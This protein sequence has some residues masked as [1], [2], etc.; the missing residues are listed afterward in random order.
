MFVYFILASFIRIEDTPINHF[1]LDN[2]PL[3]PTLMRFMF[4]SQQTSK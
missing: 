4:K 1:Y 3:P 2:Y